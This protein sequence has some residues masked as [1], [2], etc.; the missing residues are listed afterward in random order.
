MSTYVDA[1]HAGFLATW[2]SHSRILIFLN[3]AQIL[4]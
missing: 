1:D 3:R 4:W 2:P